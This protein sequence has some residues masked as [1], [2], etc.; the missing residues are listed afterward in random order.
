M[1]Q[2]TP[3]GLDARSKL[4][5]LRNEL[6]AE[7]MASWTNDPDALQTLEDVAVLLKQRLSRLR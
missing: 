1:V 5:E 4:L 7:L 6:E 3:T 2:I